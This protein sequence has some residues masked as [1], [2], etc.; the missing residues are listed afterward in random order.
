MKKEGGKRKRK[1]KRK[2]VRRIKNEM[3]GAEI[4]RR[5]YS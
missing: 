2:D 4:I 3:N 1:K 5:L